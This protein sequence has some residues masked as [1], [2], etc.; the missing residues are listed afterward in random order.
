MNVLFSAATSVASEG[1]TESPNGEHP[2]SRT[3]VIVYCGRGY[4]CVN[5]PACLSTVIYVVELLA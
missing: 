3:P 1:G 5:L 4:V 2:R